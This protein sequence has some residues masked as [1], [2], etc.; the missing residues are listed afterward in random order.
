MTDRPEVWE[1]VCHNTM[2]LKVP[3]G[4]LYR[5]YGADGS[6]GGVA[7]CFVPESK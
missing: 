6:D 7:M 1:Y 3:G 4:W 5:H 2:R